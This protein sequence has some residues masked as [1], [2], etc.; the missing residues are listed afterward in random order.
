MQNHPA[1]KYAQRLAGG[2]TP[3][4]K[5][6]RL[7][8]VRY[9]SDLDR[10]EFDTTKAEHALNFFMFLRHSKGEWANHRLEL[11]PWQQFIIWNLYGF[12][13]DDGTRRFR[14]GY[15]EVPR[16]NGKTTMLAGLG[17]LGM[18]ADDEPG[19]EIYSAATKRDQAK[20]LFDEAT[21]MVRAS[22][23]LSSRIKSHKN[24]LHIP[25]TAAKFEPLGAD[26]DT[27][28]GLNPHYN[29]IDELHAHK[30]AG[31]WNVL[32]TA[33]GARRQPLTIAITTAGQD[34]H[35][36]CWDRHTYTE[37][38]LENVIDDPSW[39]G[40]VAGIDEGDDWLDPATWAKANPNFGVSVKTEAFAEKAKQASNSP[41]TQASFMR[42][43]LN[44]WSEG[45]S[46]FIPLEHWRNCSAVPERATGRITYAGL[47]LASSNDI[48]AFVEVAPTDDPRT[49][50]VYP[51]FFIPADNISERVS[52]DRVPYDSW[53]RDGLV[54]ATPGNVI[55]F[56]S[57][58]ATIQRQ[59][60]DHQ[61]KEIAFDRWGATQISQQLTD[62][63]FTM[64][65]FGQGFASLSAPTKE[66]L[67]LVSSGGLR[68]GGNPVLEWM[69]SN[70]VVRED[71]AGN[72]KPDKSKSREKIDGMVALIMA[73]DRALRHNEKSSVY[74]SRG[75]L[76]F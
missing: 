69:A 44:V 55:D 16:K 56:E 74:E 2:E 42:L 20:L 58:R 32:D 24:N 18:L 33:T 37:K 52:K 29:L 27:L 22:S 47:D 38:V 31:L 48:A 34:M 72:I 51:H 15:I 9:L 41:A 75:V 43:R 49:F 57:I 54:T 61:I 68:H 40:F 8:A 39:F 26:K 11:E 53:V 21:R 70:M 64:V 65:G 59:G 76:S 71:P 63:G 28:D 4:N 30:T 19:A 10:F 17:L 50:D 66:L 5:W 6:Q 45:V 7:A 67:T 46:A 60:D 35:G 23:D 25:G 14:T 1:H 73:L 3:G 13:R 36:I 62:D 12:I